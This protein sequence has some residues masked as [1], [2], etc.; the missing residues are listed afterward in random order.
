MNEAEAEE[1]PESNEDKKKLV[2]H[3]N[4]QLETA[5]KQHDTFY[6][7]AEDAYKEYLSNYGVY[8]QE[9]K[10]VRRMNVFNSIVNTQLP[11]YYSRTPK[12]EVGIRKKTGGTLENVTGQAIE[13]GAQY[14]LEE[15]QDF[16]A[17]AILA[18]KSYSITG[19]G[20]LWERYEAETAVVTEN[21]RVLFDGES[22]FYEDGTEVAPESEI[23]GDE[24]QGF[25]AAKTYKKVVSEKAITEFVHY[26]D[27]LHSPARCEAD[28]SW[29]ARRAYLSKDEFRKRFPS[30]DVSD[31]KFE[32][33]PDELKESKNASKDEIKAQGKAEVWEIWH[34]EK[35]RVYWICEDYEEG[36]IEESEPPFKVKGFYPCSPAL[37]AN[38][39]ENTAVPTCDYHIIEDQIKEVERTTTRIHACLEAI[40]ANGLYDKML[41]DQMT[42]IYS[43]D[44]LMIP[45]DDFKAFAER[46]K[47]EDRIA[48][49]PVEP[50]VRALEI[51]YDAREQALAKIYEVTGNSDL[52]R[53]STNAQETATAQ[54]LKGNFA[55]LRFSLKQRQVQQFIKEQLRIKAEVMCSEFQDQT[56]YEICRGEELEEQFI[57]GEVDPQTGQPLPAEYSFAQVIEL[58]RDDIQRRYKIDIETDSMVALDEGAERQQRT[59]YL[60]SIAGFVS[61]VLPAMQQYPALAPTLMEMVMFATRSYRAGRELEGTIE[62]GLTEVRQE[63]EQQRANPQQPED[64]KMVENQIKLQIAQIEA[65]VDQQQAQIELQKAQIDA[66]LKQL[67][68]QAKV[69]E[70]QIKREQMQLEAGKTMV[71]TKAETE[72]MKLREDL[73]KVTLELQALRAQH[74]ILDKLVQ[75]PRE[76]PAAPAPAPAPAPNITLNVPSG[77]KLVKQ[78]DAGTVVIP[79]D[80]G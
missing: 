4:I 59:D 37:C 62:A 42:E 39:G 8:D 58:M 77:R 43:T 18:I 73:A 71:D 14:C 49:A 64:P 3:L 29:K 25:Y 9:D 15:C 21:L 6:K 72:K 34:K 16:D 60:N 54:Q 68:I 70:N 19:R 44:F 48:F 53:G 26:K 41:G 61:Q 57:S 75:T 74:E 31:I 12:A 36:P 66:Q 63:L 35:N 46:G 69:D 27:Y 1:L 65:Q 11:A 10:P 22:Y 47:L 56:L 78:T 50:Y 30:I 45:I 20:V 5:R 38:V 13:H 76:T 51:L 7:H 2:K 32:N 33:I 52:I 67:E 55:Q 17:A 28:I 23:V 79:L 40:R 24:M 80:E